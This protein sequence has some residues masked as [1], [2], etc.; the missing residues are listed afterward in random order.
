MRG[1]FDSRLRRS[2]NDRGGEGPLAQ[3][4]RVVSDSW[5]LTERGEWK[6]LC[7][8]RFDSLRCH[9]LNDRGAGQRGATSTETRS[10]ERFAFVKMMPLTGETSP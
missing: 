4:P 5:S 9:S 8:G 10:V 3:R 7:W 2:L 6:R 1:R